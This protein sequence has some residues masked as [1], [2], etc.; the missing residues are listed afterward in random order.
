MYSDSFL[1]NKFQQLCVLSA[2]GMYGV[3]EFGRKVEYGSSSDAS[4]NAALELDMDV[5]VAWV[6]IE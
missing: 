4:V 1:G 2:A 6:L 3:L 5:E